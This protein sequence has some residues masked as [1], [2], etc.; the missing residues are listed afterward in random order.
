M[1][2]CTFSVHQGRFVLLCG[3]R[4]IGCLGSGRSLVV[5]PAADTHLVPFSAQTQV[6]KSNYSFFI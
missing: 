3:G 4:R 1:Y 2:L 5:I 6:F